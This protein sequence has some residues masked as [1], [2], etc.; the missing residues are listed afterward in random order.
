M[1]S[2]FRRMFFRPLPEVVPPPRPE[3]V[4]EREFKDRIIAEHLAANS[5]G[6]ELLKLR[7]SKSNEKY[8]S[9]L[10]DAMAIIGDRG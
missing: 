7:A 10:D 9:M 6:R 3:K 2:L 5:K 1:P 4:I 8:I